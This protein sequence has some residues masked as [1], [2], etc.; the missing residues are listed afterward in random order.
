MRAVSSKAS[1]PGRQSRLCSGSRGA[2]RG[3]E[4]EGQRWSMKELEYPGSSRG[5][6]STLGVFDEDEDG[7]G[8]MSVL[9]RP[10]SQQ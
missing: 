8:R 3:T 9:E 6:S 7:H 4:V 1:C 10:L 2:D 5:S